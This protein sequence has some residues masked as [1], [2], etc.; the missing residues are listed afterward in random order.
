MT[1]LEKMAACPDS[2]GVKK[3]T[4]CSVFLRS[5]KQAGVV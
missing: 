4:N 1:G 5:R 3:I 2:I